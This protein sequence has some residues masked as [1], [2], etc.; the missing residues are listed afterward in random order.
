MG[1]VLR[2]ECSCGYQH[3]EIFMGGGRMNHEFNCEAPFYCEE[4]SKIKLRNLIKKRP[5]CEKCKEE[6]KIFRALDDDI[7]CEECAKLFTVDVLNERFKCG[8]CRKELKMYGEIIGYYSDKN[9]DL[10]YM[11]DLEGKS[12]NWSFL[13]DMTY[14]LPSDSNYC[15]NCKTN[16]LRFEDVGIWD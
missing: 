12:F 15:P 4:C 5:K 2:A 13:A 8:G 14:Y 16:N 1:Q 3:N 10:D 7:E 6:L 9:R 11:K